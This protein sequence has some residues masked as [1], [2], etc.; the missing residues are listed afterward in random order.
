MLINFLPLKMGAFPIAFAI[1]GSPY[2]PALYHLSP[3]LVAGGLIP[4]ITR[5][6]VSLSKYPSPSPI[7]PTARSFSLSFP[8]L[9]ILIDVFLRPA[10]ARGFISVLGAK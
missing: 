2:A 5:F 10:A 8:V 4:A 6:I 1:S 9:P 3:R 7:R